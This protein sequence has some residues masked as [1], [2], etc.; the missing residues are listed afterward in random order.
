[1]AMVDSVVSD[2]QPQPRLLHHN[3][4]MRMKKNHEIQ[5]QKNIFGKG[6]K[7]VLFLKLSFM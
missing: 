4:L 7:E 3:T 6:E 2:K 1:M 5:I